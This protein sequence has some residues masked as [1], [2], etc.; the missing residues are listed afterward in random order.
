MMRT[1][2]FWFTA[3][4]LG[5]ALNAAAQDYPSRT[6]RLI[7]PFSPGGA[8][9]TPARL[10]APKLSEALG[11]PVVVENR[12]GAGGIIGIEAAA[13]SQPDGYTM[14]VA[15][16]GELVMN[17]SIYPKLPYNP[18]ND[19]TPISIMI[20]SPLV[21]LAAAN[22]PFNSQADLLAAAKAKPGTVTYATAGTGSTSHVLTEMLALQAGGDDFFRK[23]LLNENLLRFFGG[24]QF[25]GGHRHSNLTL[26]GLT[27]LGLMPWAVFLPFVVSA[28]WRRRWSGAP[29][30]S[31]GWA[32]STGAAG[33]GPSLTLAIMDRS[34]SRLRIMPLLILLRARSGRSGSAATCSSRCW[35][36]ADAWR[37]A[38]PCSHPFVCLR[39]VNG[40]RA[41]RPTRT[42]QMLRAAR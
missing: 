16:N 33:L 10:V 12:P 41:F 24:S 18:F 8:T 31:P 40:W 2:A 35:D 11:Q 21:L 14:L 30:K 4:A 38:L 34:A 36:S 29:P 26:F 27:L 13:R 9:D 17:P 6:I 7:V 19:L 5:L 25:S 22:S 42:W 28:L 3:L 32:K 37:S 23:Q 15:T 20:E 39:T 1:A